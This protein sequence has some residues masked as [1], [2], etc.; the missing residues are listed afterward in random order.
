MLKG[1]VLLTMFGTLKGGKHQ[2]SVNLW[3]GSPASDIKAWMLSN[4]STFTGKDTSRLI[5]TEFGNIFRSEHN[6]RMVW[7]YRPTKKMYYRRL[8]NIQIK[9]IGKLEELTGTKYIDVC[10]LN[11]NNGTIL[12]MLTKDDDIISYQQFMKMSKADRLQFY[13]R[14]GQIMADISK[15]NAYYLLRK[16]ANM[17]VQGGDLTKAILL[18]IDEIYP[19]SYLEDKVKQYQNAYSIPPN[20]DMFT[21][22][23]KFLFQSFIL[24]NEKKFMSNKE[25]AKEQGLYPL[26]IRNFIHGMLDQEGD[27]GDVVR[28]F[29]EKIAAA[30]QQIN[31]VPEPPRP[32]RRRPRRRLM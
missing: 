25:L 16:F 27:I 17:I 30:E 8:F 26:E 20:V 5:H 2:C 10:H 9:I 31:E 23:P 1:F 3:A 21:Y 32:S 29:A 18:E 15:L 22:F 12:R 14:L 11:Q 4:V 6:D 13:L 7:M 19:K 24:R 28:V